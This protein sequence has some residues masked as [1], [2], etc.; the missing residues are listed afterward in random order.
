M[1]T[2]QQP[3]PPN[4]VKKFTAGRTDMAFDLIAAGMPADSK[5]RRVGLVR[6]AA[7]HGDTAIVRFLLAHDAPKSHLGPNLGLD[8]AVFHGHWQLAEYLIELG[9]DPNHADAATGERPLHKALS[10][11]NRPNYHHAVTVLLVAGA[12]PRVTTKTRAPTHA[13]M[14]AAFTRGETPL[15]RAAA[16]AEPDTIRMLMEAGADPTA[17]DAHGDTPLAWASWHLR[18]P[19]V[20]RQLLFDPH[21]IHPDNSAT[22]DHGAGW[23]QLDDAL[24][25]RPIPT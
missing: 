13:F 1:A 8:D 23:G 5:V 14:R 19:A 10:K 21:T 18:P 3:S 4:L 17:I 2:D 15:H 20:L 9:A 11:A 24:R 6:W 12:D 25:A 7:Y 22:Y 16:F